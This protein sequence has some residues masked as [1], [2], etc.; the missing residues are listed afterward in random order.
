[1]ISANQ[2][3]ARILPLRRLAL[4]RHHDRRSR[5]RRLLV[6]PDL[7]A[8]RVVG[9]GAE[10]AEQAQQVA[11]PVG[12][13]DIVEKVKPAVISVRV[14]VRADAQTSGIDGENPFPHGLADGE[15]FRRFGMPDAEGMPRSAPRGRQSARRRARASS[16]RLTAMP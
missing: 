11:R 9:A 6:A 5:C 8:I 3:K 16:S 10:P 4:A 12:F 2:S 1:M 13:A 15:F 14:K 7:V